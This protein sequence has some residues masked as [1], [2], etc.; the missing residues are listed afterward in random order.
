LGGEHLKALEAISRLK[1]LDL[2]LMDAWAADC[3]GNG[4]T[5]LVTRLPCL[6]ILAAPYDVLVRQKCK[7]TPAAS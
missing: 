2:R 7:H 1:V 4:L 3:I 5:S 6:R